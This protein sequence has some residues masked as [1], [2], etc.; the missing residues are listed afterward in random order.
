MR[1]VQGLIAVRL[2]VPSDR[3]GW[4][5]GF[6]R[7]GPLR[8]GIDWGWSK[9]HLQAPRRILAVFQSPAANPRPWRAREKPIWILQPLVTPQHF[10]PVGVALFEDCGTQNQNR[11]GTCGARIAGPRMC[12]PVDD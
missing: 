11:R 3:D 5:W 9:L 2:R 6:T 1:L 12:Q 10:A 7:T 4:T 8:I